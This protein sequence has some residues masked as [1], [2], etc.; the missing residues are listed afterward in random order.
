MNFGKNSFFF[1]NDHRMY[2]FYKSQLL[3]IEMP[4]YLGFNCLIVSKMIQTGLLHSIARHFDHWLEHIDDF[5]T[6]MEKLTVLQPIFDKIHSCGDIDR[7]AKKLAYW[8]YS[9]LF[10]LIKNDGSIITL[11]QGINYTIGLKTIF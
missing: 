3:H 10:N 11:C 4:K 2:Q 7:D 6:V 8:E 1:T 9:Q 5:H